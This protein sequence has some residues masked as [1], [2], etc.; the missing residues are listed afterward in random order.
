VDVGKSGGKDA[1][2]DGEDFAAD[3]NGFGEIAG[4]VRERGKEKI[5]EI[6]AGEAAAN[7]KTVLEEAAEKGFVLGKSDHAVADV[8]GRE[9]TIL[10]AQAAGTAA[11]IG[12][13]DDG[14]EIGDGAIAAGVVIGAADDVFFQAAEEGGEA[15][16]ST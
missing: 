8:A 1:A 6:V 2:A 15:G 12:D 4:D 3:A 14:G 7:M 10:A 5:A 11:V 16:A 9:N 13:G